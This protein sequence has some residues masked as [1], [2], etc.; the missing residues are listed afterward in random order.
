MTTITAMPVPGNGRTSTGV[1]AWALSILVSLVFLVFCVGLLKS[2]RMFDEMFKNL[3]VQ[4]PL[5][6]RFLVANY[7]WLFPL[8]YG[9][10]AAF[11]IVKEFVMRSVPH[12]LIT[13]ALVLV[14]GMW[15]LG[16]L[17]FVLY[18]SVFDLMRKLAT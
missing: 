5:P 14:A 11:L 13:S 15:S 4:L 6:T 3:D 9:G 18:L 1:L 10:G 8:F 12:R 16:L 2:I 7:V 17:H